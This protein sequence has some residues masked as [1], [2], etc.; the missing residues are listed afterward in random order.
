MP[1]PSPNSFSCAQPPPFP[2]PLPLAPESLLPPFVNRE[3]K[4]NYGRKTPEGND[5]LIDCPALHSPP[6]PPC[7]SA[8]ASCLY[9]AR[10]GPR[11]RSRR[12]P[13][14][15]HAPSGSSTTRSV[16]G[17]TPSSATGTRGPSRTGEAA[18]P[19]PGAL[20]PRWSHLLPPSSPCKTLAAEASP[21]DFPA[22]S[23][24]CSVTGSG[25]FDP[26]WARKKL[27]VFGL[28]VTAYLPCLT[29]GTVLV[30]LQ[31]RHSCRER[32]GSKPCPLQVGAQGSRQ[33]R[34]REGHS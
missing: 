19:T 15:S 12:Q 27:A 26:C 2:P 32:G 13:L 21:P 23:S 29:T 30:S 28:P 34:R 24:T 18:R 5:R 10:E 16:L 8:T 3:A 25:G 31:L 4:P 17:N 6:P 22:P 20:V 9:G 1:A 7:R 11:Q 14:R 33:G